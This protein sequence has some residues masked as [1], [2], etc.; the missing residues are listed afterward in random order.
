MRNFLK[1][2]VVLLIVTLMT[3]STTTVM[4]NTFEVQ[5]HE[6]GLRTTLDTLLFENFDGA[7]VGSPS[8]PIDWI[9]YC[10]N[11]SAEIW[12]PNTV[13]Y[14]SPPNSAYRGGFGSSLLSDDWL[15]TPEI[16]VE[17]YVNI[18]LSWWE[19]HGWLEYYSNFCGLWISCGS[20]DPN[21]GDY[22]LI[23]ERPPPAQGVGDWEFYN[24]NLDTY[25]TDDTFFIAWEYDKTSTGMTSC[26]NID[27]VEITGDFVEPCE[28]SIDVE[29]EVKDKNG[30]WQDAD[31]ENEAADVLI[32]HN[33][34]YRITITNTGD[35]PLINIIVRD[36]MHKSLT[37]ISSDPE[38]ESWFEEPYWYIEWFFPGPLEVNGT[39]IITITAHVEGPECSIDPNHVNVS[40][41]CIHEKPV[42]DA[43]SCYV[44][45]GEET[46]RALDRPFLRF[47]QSYP[48]LFRIMEKLLQR[49]R[50][51]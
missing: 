32:C 2:A 17:S 27:D 12:Q 19:R 44:H 5:L 45:C 24:V 33:I 11:P 36:M 14:I 50:L 30:T 3:L 6:S 41:T 22:V 26:W 40:A 9:Q 43:D 16:N 13:R 49:L 20:P 38:G 31:T 25:L 10:T 47:L 29:K 21:D 23:M 28:P 18:Q 37:Y 15:V 34:T 7:W 46:S 39:I 8:A 51:Q 1:G 4:A 48:N 35:C 42:S